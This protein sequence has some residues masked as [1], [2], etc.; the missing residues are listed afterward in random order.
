M[1]DSGL[2]AALASLKAAKDVAEA[3]LSVSETTDLQS[4][5]IEF[6]SKIIDANNAANEAQ[7]ERAALYE[8]IGT[9]EQEVADLDTWNTEK[10]NYQLKD[11][12]SGRGG[13]AYVLKEDADTRDPP[14]S[15]C[16]NCFQRGEKS[17]LQRETRNPGRAYV[18]VCHNCGLDIYISGSWAPEHARANAL[19]QANRS[20]P[21][22]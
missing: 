22:R 8:R 19:R 1:A 20:E 21:A 10:Q 13:F 9:L 14:H 5:M 18:L 6:Q 15:L 4:R 11:V 7:Y 16:A 17:I 3:M 12:T 2:A